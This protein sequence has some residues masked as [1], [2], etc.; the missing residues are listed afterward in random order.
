MDALHIADRG[1]PRMMYES[2][3][4]CG[5]ISMIR[6]LLTLLQPSKPSSWLF[7]FRLLCACTVATAYTLTG[8]YEKS[9][10]VWTG[11]AGLR[12]CAVLVRHKD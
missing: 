9:L 5:L 6:T 2:A 11:R 3:A 10:F 1:V 4:P 8:R 12:H 7:V